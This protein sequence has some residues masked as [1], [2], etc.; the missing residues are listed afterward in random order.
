MRAAYAALVLGL[1]GGVGLTTV[2]LSGVR[3]PPATVAAALALDEGPGLDA[4]R[5][6]A[7]AGLITTCM[8]QHGIVWHAVPEPVPS[9]PDSSLDP[10]AWADRWGFGVSTMA[11]SPMPS[12]VPDP[13]LAALVGM[14]PRVQA[15][16]RATLHGSPSGPGCVERATQE[17]YGLRERSLRPIRE[18]LV[19]LETT[20]DADPAARAAVARWRGCVN[21]VSDGLASERS[22]LGAALVERAVRRLGDVRAGT[23]DLASV[24]R[25]ERWTAGVLARCEQAFGEARTRIAARYEAAFV[26]RYGDRLA[27]IGTA[28]RSAE[29]AWPSAAP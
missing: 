20:I 21:G 11:G 13:D 24:Q 19:Q 5:A 18:A 23:A 17:V 12:P 6:V 26:A 16:V 22:T 3:P 7:V 28:I 2:V 10:V 9:I 4:R 15:V 29:A 8:R 14:T 27:A 1:L 25:D